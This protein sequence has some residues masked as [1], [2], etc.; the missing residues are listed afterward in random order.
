MKRLCHLLVLTVAALGLRAAD[1]EWLDR[2]DAALSF[3]SSDDLLR[4]RVSG[5]AEVEG[6][7]FRQPAPGLLAST[8][9]RLFT[10]RLVLFADAQL[11]SELYFFAQARVD[12]GFDP[13]W[14]STGAQ[15]DEFALR[16]TPWAS[17]AANVQIGKF[18]TVVGNWVE[19][20]QAWDNPFVTAP[21]P[22]ENPTGIFGNRAARSPGALL[23]WAHVGPGNEAADPD[24][25]RYRLPVI[26][27]PSYA[28]GAAVSGRF[29]PL[30]AAVEIKNAGLSSHPDDWDI[31]STRWEQPTVSA[32]IGYRPD[33]RWNF[34]VSASTGSYLEAEAAPP[35]APGHGRSDYRQTLL[36][37]DI[38]YAWHHWQWWFECYAVRFAI[39]GVG[40]ADT[41]AYYFETKY[42]FAPQW[43]GA[44][45]WNQQIFGRIAAGP[46]GTVRWGRDDWR[47]DWAV[48]YRFT[49]HS[50]LKLE[51]DLEHGR[52][53]RTSVTP[54][55]AG[56]LLLRF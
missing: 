22:Y 10:P 3:R 37:Q 47:T 34:G 1:D 26:W 55:F 2:L 39:P 38:A 36:G 53:P 16:W 31:S 21:L 15:L 33:P 7:A 46:A 6:Y 4:L 30:E 19:R 24:A 8:G 9:D 14:R 48:G 44:V 20:H 27:G 5:L 43:Y 52:V 12:R 45:R 40:P 13:G 42:H 17:G 25:D 32:R 51:L 11:G 56:Q 41:L 18:A 23:A 49:P 28:S 54:T 29:G 35:L 50:E